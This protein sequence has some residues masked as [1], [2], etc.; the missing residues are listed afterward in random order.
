MTNTVF[1]TMVLY[2][3]AFVWFMFQPT[4]NTDNFIIVL[5]FGMIFFA[6][7]VIEAIFT[8]LSKEGK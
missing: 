8:C 4:Y 6:T 5:V 3:L 2:F 7:V 1:S